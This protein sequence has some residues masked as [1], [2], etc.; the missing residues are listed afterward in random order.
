[1][2]KLVQPSEIVKKWG[3]FKVDK[4]NLNSL[5][6]YRSDAIKIFDSTGWQ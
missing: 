2:N 3:E 6:E 5:G 1:V 4:L